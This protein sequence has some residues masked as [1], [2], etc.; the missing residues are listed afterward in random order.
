LPSPPG[1]FPSPGGS[2]QSPGSPQGPLTSPAGFP[3]E[4]ILAE[5]ELAADQLLSSA[6]P[7]SL[8][9][10]SSAAQGGWIVGSQDV[11][12]FN[13]FT[14]IAASGDILSAL[15]GGQ[16]SDPLTGVTAESDN[17]NSYTRGHNVD[18]FSGGQ[19][20]ESFT[21]GGGSA[22]AS[23]AASSSLMLDFG[24]GTI[25]TGS[26]TEK[27]PVADL[28]QYY[29]QQSLTPY[30][31]DAELLKAIQE[32]AGPY[33]PNFYNTGQPGSINDVLSGS[34]WASSAAPPAAPPAAATG[35]SPANFF[36]DLTPGER[37]ALYAPWA[38]GLFSSLAGDSLTTPAAAT[39]SAPAALPDTFV[40]GP[41]ERAAFYAHW[42]A[43]LFSSPGGGASLTAAAVSV[44]S[45]AA[46]PASQPRPP[47]P[48]TEQDRGFFSGLENS[49]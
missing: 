24:I 31:P 34:E 28:A 29:Q 44:G 32:A 20:V 19:N 42:A 26:G 37:A 35:S 1:P 12:W 18:H 9:D 21:G 17:A 40:G 4:T 46:T 38:A 3:D 5:I 6:V 14:G 25:V 22:T 36:N 39:A 45:P 2:P 48:A 43:G 49:C 33:D 47:S 30:D 8:P 13:W 23:P 27:A 11:D 7:N 10:R 16:T 15:T 41:N